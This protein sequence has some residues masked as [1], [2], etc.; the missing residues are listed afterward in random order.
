MV[1]LAHT[2]TQTASGEA[3]D[4]N[5]RQREPHVE[6][7]APCTGKEGC[8]AMVALACMHVKSYSYSK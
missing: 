7:P 6:E 3:R 5:A 4:S 1:T 2:L 8:Q